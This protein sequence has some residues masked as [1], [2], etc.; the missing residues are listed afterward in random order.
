MNSRRFFVKRLLI[1]LE[2]GIGSACVRGMAA[3]EARQGS[4]G[5][6]VRVCRQ[7]NASGSPPST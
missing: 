1:D 6:P 7:Q 2:V 3:M 4:S 5:I